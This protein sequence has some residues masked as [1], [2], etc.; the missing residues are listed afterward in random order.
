MHAILQRSAEKCP[1][2]SSTKLVH[3]YN[4]GETVCGGCGLVLARNAYMQTQLEFI[5][6]SSPLRFD[7]G[8]YGELVDLIC[9]DAQ[10]LP[11]LPHY[12]REGAKRIIKLVRTHYPTQGRRR[13]AIVVVAL[14]IARGDHDVNDLKDLLHRAKHLRA[15]KR[16]KGN[17]IPQKQIENTFEELRTFL[18]PKILHIYKSNRRCAYARKLRSEEKRVLRSLCKKRSQLER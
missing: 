7:L 5:H 10:N 8:K 18:E 3:D 14:S 9:E 15:S 2:C 12:L 16:I 17:E 13:I 4:T 1:E 11:Q 6:H